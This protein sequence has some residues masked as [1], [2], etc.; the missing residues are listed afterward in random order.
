MNI[1]EIK[2]SRNV[3]INN[4]DYEMTDFF[5]TATGTADHGESITRE[6]IN[7]LSRAVEDTMLGWLEN[8]YKH[9]GKSTTR[10]K[11]A[12]THGLSLAVSRQ[13]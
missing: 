4:G 6:D 8:V 11:I 13:K 2:V 5:L 9:K 3:K 7:K 12:K 1:T 10:E